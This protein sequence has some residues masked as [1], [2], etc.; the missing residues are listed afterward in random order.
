M[1][2]PIDFIIPT[3]N[4]PQ[5]LQ[6]ALKS[7][8]NQ[9]VSPSRIIVVD[10]G[11]NPETRC[12]V[13][14]AVSLKSDGSVEYL[15]SKPFSGRGA[16][17]AG[18]RSAT[19][20]WIILLDDDDFLVPD[21]I[22]HDLELIRSAPERTAIIQHSFLRVDYNLRRIW[23]HDAPANGLDLLHALKMRNFGP[24]PSCTLNRE[25]AASSHRF[26]EESGWFDYDLYAGMLRNG[27]AISA[28]GIGYIMDDTRVA[29]GRETSNGEKNA[30]LTLLHGER[31]IPDS[32]LSECEQ[33]EVSQF[34]A[35]EAAFYLGKGEGVAAFS[36]GMAAL[37]RRYPVSVMKGMAATIRYRWLCWLP[38]SARGSQ[39]LS[40]KAMGR[41]DRS[42]MQWI[43]N[44]RI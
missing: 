27:T 5:K 33:L 34:L 14:D 39:M 18:I 36:G 22:E 16:L 26:D 29:V 15:R 30:R 7:V 17:A 4:R 20:D 6:R 35:R 28:A 40:F 37:A 9:T 21:R 23:W 43:E 12:V 8:F 25:I 3:Y 19:A 41:R 2:A 1:T 31:H 10:N 32:D 44:N 38:F 24:P 13:K 42:L 11:E